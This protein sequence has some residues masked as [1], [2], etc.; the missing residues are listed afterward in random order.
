MLAGHWSSA[1]A[2]ITLYFGMPDGL[3]QMPSGIA[4]FDYVVEGDELSTIQR[5]SREKRRTRLRVEG[6]A[7][8]LI[9]GPGKLVDDDEVWFSRV[10]QGGASNLA[11]MSLG[12]RACWHGARM[13][14]RGVPPFVPFFLL[15]DGGMASM[16]GSSA[17]ECL[18]LGERYF[19][20]RL[21]SAARAAF[22]VPGS[23][24]RPD[25]AEMEVAIA[26]V[27]IAGVGS[28]AWAMGY[29][30]STTPQGVLGFG[31][32]PRDPSLDWLAL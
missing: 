23:V 26:R 25:G 32:G 15:E 30:P 28:D 24:R 9:G 14:G 7:L 4:F 1:P 13:A 10:T 2:G 8:V 18:A 3:M 21:R 12:H 29:D 22:V 11:L 19:T 17:E 20:T 31:P 5:V 27:T 6:D 16:R